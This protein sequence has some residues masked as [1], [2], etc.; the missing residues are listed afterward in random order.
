MRIHAVQHGYFGDLVCVCVANTNQINGVDF[1]L[2]VF[3]IAFEV[4][5][6]F[7]FFSYRTLRMMCMCVLMYFVYV[8]QRQH[9]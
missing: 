9:I 5:F 4:F 7:W 3:S 1:G 6:S 2:V 8:V